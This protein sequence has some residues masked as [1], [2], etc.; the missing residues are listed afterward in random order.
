[1]KPNFISS[2]LAGAVMLTAVPA[3]SIEILFA[4]VGDYGTYVD[5]GNRIAAMAGGAAGANV[6]VRHL[7]QAVYNDY[8]LFDQVWVYDLYH[9]ADESATQVDNYQAIANWYNDG[10]A[11]NM[12]VDGRIISS[13][14]AW[15]NPPETA[16]IQNY[17]SELDQRGG[18]LMLGTDHDV[19]ANSGFNRL[20]DL[21][22]VGP[23]TGSSAG[24][25]AVVDPLSPLW[26][27]GLIPCGAGETCINDNSSTG[28]VPTGLQANGQTLTPVAYHGTTSTA[29]DNA[30]VSS[31]MGSRTFNTCGNPGQ[32]P[33]DP[34][35]VPAP[36]TLLLVIAALLGMGRVR[37]SQA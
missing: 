31:T 23:V 28:F 13:D 17:V 21:L 9:L 25:L 37:R 7:N 1:M 2:L 32:P 20:L 3:H 15:R 36:G 29:F 5:D 24:P 22:M 33:C 12:I 8:G 34:N 6:T 26:I 30:A 18:G 4:H 35:N 11:Q 27:P 16:Y 10:R 19:F 14:I